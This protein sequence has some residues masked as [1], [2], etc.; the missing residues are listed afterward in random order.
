M[1]KG[2]YLDYLPMI[3]GHRNA[4]PFSV[5]CLS[6][7]VSLLLVLLHLPALNFWRGIQNRAAGVRRPA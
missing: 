2:I 6:A 5:A 4:K 3:T 1:I 7:N